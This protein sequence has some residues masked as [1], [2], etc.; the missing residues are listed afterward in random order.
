[1]GLL[2]F[3]GEQVDPEMYNQRLFRNGADCCRRSWIASTMGRCAVWWW[4]D[5]PIRRWRRS[6]SSAGALAKIETKRLMSVNVSKNDHS[7]R[8]L[9]RWNDSEGH[10]GGDRTAIWQRPGSALH[11]ICRPRVDRLAD[12]SHLCTGNAVGSLVGGTPRSGEDN[13]VAGHPLEYRPADEKPKLNARIT[14]PGDQTPQLLAAHG[15]AF[16][17]PHTERAGVYTIS[18]TDALGKQQTHQMAASFD[19][20]ASDLEPVTERQ[21][22]DLLGNLKPILVVYHPRRAGFGGAR[23]RDLAEIWRSR[24]Y[25]C[26]WW[27]RCMAFY[28]GRER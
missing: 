19:K 23:P 11:H 12:R 28:V 27:S 26:S 3:C 17:F 20:N 15:T 21:L 4:R 8:V 9:A 2:I 24:F 6:R 5:L 16:A 18:W 25:V 10:P 1:M 22:A 7:T 13:L 14:I